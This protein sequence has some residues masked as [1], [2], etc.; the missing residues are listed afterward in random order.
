MPPVAVGLALLSTVLHVGW[1]AA[2]R[3]SA[4]TIRFVWL[5][6]L[7]GG[8]LGALVA[9][10]VGHWAVRGAAPWVIATIGIHVVYFVAL[11]G[12]YRAGGLSVVYPGSRGL[13]VLLTVP[14]AA[15]LF[16]QAPSA[17]VAVGIALVAFGLVGTTWSAASRPTT[18]SLVWTA[19]VGVT[20]TA[21]SLVD[22]HAV[23]LMAPPLYISLQ[24]LG[25]ALVLTPLALRESVPA[26]AAGR[27]ALLAG[28]GS[29][30]SYLL[31]LYAYRMAPVAAVLALRQ[32]GPALAP[33]VAALWLRERPSWQQ[34]AGA[35]AIAVGGLL[36]IAG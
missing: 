1:N 10:A 3:G 5:Q 35:M 14:A 2:M 22:S 23:L 9:L 20:I 16:A 13:G 27:T 7:A 33:V 25:T 32:L 24:F 12:A 19:L 31:I 28:V 26:P 11:V 18:K 8:V 6:T 29:L 4:A 30:V 15:A 34:A 21:Y 17:G 36:V